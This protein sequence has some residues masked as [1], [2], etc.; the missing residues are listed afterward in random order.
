[1]R[2]GPRDAVRLRKYS[3]L[4]IEGQPLR[5][6]CEREPVLE[7]LE[8]AR[9][10]AET[11]QRE[12]AATIDPADQ[13]FLIQPHG[14]RGGFRYVLTNGPTGAIFSVKAN[15]DPGE[16]NLFISVPAACLLTKGYEGAKQWLFDTIAGMGGSITDHS[17]NRLDYA[18]D[19]LATDFTLDMA[20]FV[21]PGHAKISARWE[22]AQSAG[23][24]GEPIQPVMRGGRF[25]T[26]TIGK[27]PGRQV[28]LYDKRR[29]GIDTKELHW[30]KEWG[31]DRSDPGQQVWRVEI[32]AGKKALEK[33]HIKR[34]FDAVD[35]DF[36]AFLLKAVQEIRYVIGKVEDSNVSRAVTHPLWIGAA[37]ALERLP[38]TVAPPLPEAHVLD[39]MRKQRR[40]MGVQQAFANLINV[41]VLDGVPMERIQT[42]FRNLVS[43]R[44]ARYVEDQGEDVLLQKIADSDERLRFLFSADRTK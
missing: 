39:L 4:E 6:E 22:D 14:Q 3:R 9:E 11:T 25:E 40:S 36:P 43:D 29:A 10:I 16:W 35:A 8:A 37:D 44:A 31:V 1:M 24:S 23:G 42:R 32:R 21:T 2:N 26:V 7:R 5:R 38:M 19:M 33:G 34:S 41:M 12:Q 30:F 27:M 13:R 17:V 28:I 20:S 18:V 15:P